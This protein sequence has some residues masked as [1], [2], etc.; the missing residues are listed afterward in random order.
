MDF[1]NGH[2]VKS[3]KNLTD[4]QILSAFYNS[5]KG[6]SCFTLQ[7]RMSYTVLRILQDSCD[8][9]TSGI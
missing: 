9:A 5:V 8:R 4:F 2:M 6:L 7:S 1:T 3:R